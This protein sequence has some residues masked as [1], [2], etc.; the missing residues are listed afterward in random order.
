MYRN[1]LFALLFFFNA[2]AFAQDNQINVNSKISDVTVFMNGAQVQR[3]SDNVELPQG[4]SLLVFSGLSSSIETQSLQAKGEGNFTILSVTKQNNFLLDKKKSDQKAALQAKS[5]DLTDKIVVL[6]NEIAVYKAEEEMLMKN[7]TVMGPNVNYDLVKL[8]AAL[9]FQKLRLNEAKNKQA[10]L[11]KEVAKLYEEINKINRQAAEVDGK[12]IRN[13][14]DVV[15]KVA[16]KT[17]TKGKFS[18]TYLVKNAGWYPTYDIR[19][20]DVVSPIQLVY[21]ANVSQ[22]SGEDWKNVKLVLSSGNPS[23]NNEKPTLPIYQLGYLSAGYSFFNP[24]AATSNVVKGKVV[25]AGDNLALPGASVRVKN[26]SIATVTDADGNYSIQMPIGSNT[27]EFNYIGFERQELVATAG[28]QLNVRLNEDSKR[29]EEVVVAG[30]GTAKAKNV[31]GSVTKIRG[32]SSISSVPLE[33]KNVERQTNV[34]FE[35]KTSY[36]ILSDGKQ[37]AVDIGNYDFKADYEYYAVPKVT[38]DAF[39]TAKI[40][41]FN[42]VNLISGE[43]SIFFEGTYLGKSLLDIQNTDTLTI[44]LGAD[45]NVSVK[46]EKQKGYTERQFIGSSQKDTRHFVI[47]VKNRKS[48]V[49]NLTIEDQLPVPT[50]SDITVEKQELSKAKLEE[51]SGRLTWQFLLQPNEQ[52]KIDLKYQVKYPKNRPVNIE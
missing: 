7:Q 6:N 16:A 13:S 27:L 4:V 51:T 47:D 32:V 23:N 25:S 36:T 49:V 18:I 40:T 35:I 1:L 24:V 3:L 42:E 21:K 38:Q 37:A 19:A 41:D 52:K 12:P 14:S 48:Q 44:S 9:D 22:N 28:Q 5:E 8:K 11:Q 2:A 34:T 30:Y 31:T 33:V 43:A 15:V 29:L 46:R 45:K 39:L 50:N 10:S 17:A 20:K 26:S